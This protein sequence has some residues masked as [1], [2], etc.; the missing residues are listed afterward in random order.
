M[1]SFIIGEEKNRKIKP[2][3]KTHH[4]WWG[5]YEMQIKPNCILYHWW[6]GEIKI[7]NRT[8][9]IAKVH[10]ML[11][12]DDSVS[13]KVRLTAHRLWIRET[14]RRINAYA[15]QPLLP[16]ALNSSEDGQSVN[17]P[18]D[19]SPKKKLFIP[20]GKFYQNQLTGAGV[21]SN[22]KQGEWIFMPRRGVRYMWLS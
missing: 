1:V 6:R 2:N 17:L 9:K 11:H 13:P 14:R 12:L 3:G 15:W 16:K 21:S 18:L 8:V 20:G 4:N 10:P 7:S 19:Y 5:K 22:L